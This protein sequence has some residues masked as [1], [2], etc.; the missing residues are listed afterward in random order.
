V[1]VILVSVHCQ[2]VVDRAV[3][4]AIVVEFQLSI[5]FLVLLGKLHKLPV[6]FSTC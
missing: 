4:A 6:I 2:R 1:L 3:L 5:V